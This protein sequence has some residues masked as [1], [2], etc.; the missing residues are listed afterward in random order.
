M[1]RK[2][3]KPVILLFIAV[4]FT[5]INFA[6]TV[7]IGTQV[8]MTKNLDVDK[9]RNGD[10]IPQAK[11]NAEW[12]SAGKNKQPAWCYYDNNPL[13]G[14][15]FGK[16]YNWYAVNDPRGL[17]I[18]GFHIPNDNEIAELT[19]FLGGEDLDGFNAIGITLKS[20]TGWEENGTNTSGFTAL[21]GGKRD[22]NNFYSHI[23]LIGYW[24]T[25][26]ELSENIASFFSLYLDSSEGGGTRKN[27]GMS[28]RCI[29]N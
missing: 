28:V 29:K 7:T 22:I 14:E 24:W 13:N 16:L 25:S 10:P 2:K 26:T 20:E 4:L 27:L 6:Q 1:S 11:T 17:A 21:P 5:Q 15:K 9:F 12:E 18:E 8:W 3:L 23:N 19:D